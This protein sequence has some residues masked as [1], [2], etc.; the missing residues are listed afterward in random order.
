M[1]RRS[2]AVEL[3][4]T[5]ELNKLLHSIETAYLNIVREVVEYAVKHNVTNATQ[6]H[7]LFYSKYRQEYP[8]LNSQLIIQAIRQAS[9][10]AKSFVERRRMGLVSKPYPEVRSVSLRFVET[11]WNYEEFIKSIAPVR[12]SLSLLGRRREVWLRP[13]KRFW[14]FWWRVLN[15]EAELASTL[16]IKRRANRWYAV[17]VF[18]IKPRQEVP[19]RVVAFDINENT[20]AVGKIDLP[21]TVDRVVDWN[22]QYLTPQLYM[23]RTDF[24]RLARR[25]ER[26]RNTIIERLKPEFALTEW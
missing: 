13:H 7:G 25:Y 6:L 15:G 21:S 11:T 2:V 5:R 17:F 9:G 10:V 23:I 12:L 20:V 22:R 19:Q 26:V 16:L 18:E 4:V 24:G 14:L 8:S 3:E 1:L